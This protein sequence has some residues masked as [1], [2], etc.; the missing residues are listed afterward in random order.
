MLYA[1]LV[2]FL[3]VAIVTFN[4][5]HLLLVGDNATLDT[6][7]QIQQ[8]LRDGVPL[9]P[10]VVWCATADQMGRSPRCPECPT[11]QLTL[12]SMGSYAN[13]AVAK[14]QLESN[15][16][17]TNRIMVLPI[18]TSIEMDLVVLFTWFNSIVVTVC[19]D[20]AIRVLA[21]GRHFTYSVQRKMLS[22]FT[23]NELFASNTFG[24]LMFRVEWQRWPPRPAVT[25]LYIAIMMAPYSFLV[26]DERNDKLWLASANLAL[27]QIIGDTLHFKIHIFYRWRPTCPACFEPLPMARNNRGCARLLDYDDIVNYDT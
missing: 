27:L 24:A 8:R 22:T 5:E 23:D 9:L 6:L 7:I 14:K 11:S 26:R 16:R 12:V 25:A 19:P 21:W 13:F 1:R 20:G 15:H 18:E 10:T 2:H 3:Q 4:M 17:E